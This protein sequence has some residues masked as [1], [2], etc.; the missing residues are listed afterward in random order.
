MINGL[1]QLVRDKVTSYLLTF[2]IGNL[3]EK[4]FDTLVKLILSKDYK[5]IDIYI[6]LHR[7]IDLQDISYIDNLSMDYGR[8]VSI[9]SYSSV[10][11]TLF[12]NIF[13]NTSK[14]YSDIWHNGKYVHVHYIRFII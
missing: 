13:N 1:P 14:F 3:D 11:L 2:H 8:V 4:K 7:Y 6:G 10:C 12:Y 5:S 9:T